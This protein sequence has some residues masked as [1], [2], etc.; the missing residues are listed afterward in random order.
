MLF[1]HNSKGSYDIHD[2]IEVFQILKSIFPTFG[3]IRTKMSID[4]DLWKVHQKRIHILEEGYASSLEYKTA[5]FGFLIFLG[6]FLNQIIDWLHQHFYTFSNS[7]WI[8]QAT[9]I[10]YL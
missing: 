5:R 3:Y 9:D 8:L 6:V 2:Q 1:L 4:F 10:K 7:F